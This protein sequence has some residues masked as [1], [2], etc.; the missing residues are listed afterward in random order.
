MVKKDP[1]KKGVFRKT[2]GHERLSKVP[3]TLR[4]ERREI[5]GW[6][7]LCGDLMADVEEE[8][9]GKLNERK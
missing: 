5:F 9:D 6:R 2:S 1:E 4:T 3:N 8:G 7:A